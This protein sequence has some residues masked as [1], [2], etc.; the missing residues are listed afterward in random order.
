MVGKHY[1]E[2]LKLKMKICNK[3]IILCTVNR[4]DYFSLGVENRSAFS[5]VFGS[6]TKLFP[7]QRV[8][9]FIE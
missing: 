5:I 3:T 7:P 6:H 1:C 2:L 8:L 4:P 9:R